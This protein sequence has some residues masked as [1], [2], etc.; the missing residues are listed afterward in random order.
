[1]STTVNIDP[2]V[3]KA[4]ATFVVWASNIALTL[5]F[6]HAPFLNWP[7]LNWIIKQI[8]N[9]FINKE[10]KT[11]EKIAFFANSKVRALDQAKDFE[12]KSDKVE[13]LPDDVSDED[14]EKAELE[15]MAAFSDLMHYAR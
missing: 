14:W 12:S 9:W 2:F 13:G 7:P 4:Q 5:I 8:V 6:T 15:K 1:M 3:K 11:A 10:S